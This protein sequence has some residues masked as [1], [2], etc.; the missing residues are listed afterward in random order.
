MRHTA[1]GGTAKHP[2][3]RSDY[4]GSGQLDAPPPRLTTLRAKRWAQRIRE[5]LGKEVSR[6]ARVKVT[7]PKL[8]FLENARDGEFDV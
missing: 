4:L 7:L 5:E 6:A 1:Q 3:L 2:S 8:K